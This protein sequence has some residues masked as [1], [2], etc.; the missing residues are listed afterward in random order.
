MATIILSTYR[1]SRS[2]EQNAIAHNEA[3]ALLGPLRPVSVVG[4]YKG[5]L[6][7]YIMLT[8]DVSS[9]PV[10][11]RVAKVLGQETILAR[12]DNEDCYL[13]SCE[14]LSWTYLG[15]W[16]EVSREVAEGHDSWSRVG[17]SFYVAV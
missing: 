3:L 11:A 16:T 7:Q 14:D 10:W 13:V 15:V 9:V 6:E 1:A 5:T 4:C 2:T 17:D 12:G 8:V